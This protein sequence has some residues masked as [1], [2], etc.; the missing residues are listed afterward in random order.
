MAQWHLG[1]ASFLAI[2]ALKSCSKNKKHLGQSVHAGLLHPQQPS[3][4]IRLFGI[5]Q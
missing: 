1:E 4:Q 2:A 3:V 5:G